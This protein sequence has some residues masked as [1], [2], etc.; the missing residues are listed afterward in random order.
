MTLGRNPDEWL[1]LGL[2]QPLVAALLAFSVVVAMRGITGAF[3]GA[4]PKGATS[5]SSATIAVQLWAICFSLLVGAM[6][7]TAV[8]SR[9]PTSPSDGTNQRAKALE[10]RLEVSSNEAAPAVA[11]VKVTQ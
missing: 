6:L 7:L 8:I 1:R 9:S 10:T 2:L 4:S 11:T 3:V 5:A